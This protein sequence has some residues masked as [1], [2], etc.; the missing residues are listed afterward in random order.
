[1]LEHIG[2]FMGYNI[3][4][5]GMLYSARSAQK[6]FTSWTRSFM[7]Q[8]YLF[9]EFESQICIQ[10]PDL[11]SVLYRLKKTRERF[12]IVLACLLVTF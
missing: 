5:G 11:F 2:H 7:L 6:T 1:M 9:L 3:E 4:Y 10:K 12:S 8:E